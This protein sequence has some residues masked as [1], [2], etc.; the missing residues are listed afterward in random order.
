MDDFGVAARK[1]L[2]ESKGIDL[3]LILAI[4]ASV[5]RVD[6]DDGNDGQ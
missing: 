6:K 2:K 4:V 1:S 5:D 3:E